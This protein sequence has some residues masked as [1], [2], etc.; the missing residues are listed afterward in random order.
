MLEDID[1]TQIE[2]LATARQ[3]ITRVLNLLETAWQETTD[4]KTE[5][6][7]LRDEVRQLKGE[8][9]VPK[10]KPRSKTSR[11]YSSEKERHKKTPRKK[12]SK[13]ARLVISR[14]EVLRLE[15][16]RLPED[17]QK[18]GY[19]DTVIQELRLVVET[20]RYRREKYYSPSTNQTYTAP[21]PAGYTGQFGPRAKAWALTLYYGA[22]L[23]EP[24]LLEFLATVG[25]SV[26]AT[27]LSS[28]LIEEYQPLWA[29]E[30]GALLKAGLASTSFAHLDQTSTPLNGKN[31]VTNILCNPFY[32]AYVTTEQADRLSVLRAL[33][34]GQAPTFHKTSLAEQLLVS[35]GL[36]QKWRVKLAGLGAEEV[37]SEKQLDQWL[38]KNLPG[39]GKQSRKLIKDALAIGAYQAQTEWPIVSTLICDDAAQFKLITLQLA[40]CWVHHARHYKLLTPKVV[41]HQKLLQDFLQRF[42]KYY[43]KLLAYSKLRA[44]DIE[45]AG[46]LR[47]EF[48]QLFAATGEYSQ[49]DARKA[50]SREQQT[51]LLMVLSQPEL[52][53][54]NNPAELGARQRVRKRDVSLQAVSEQG[55]SAW[56]SLQ[57]L[58]ATTKKLGVN[59]YE[60]LLDRLSGS[61]QLPSLPSLILERAEQGYSYQPSPKAQAK[62]LLGR[63]AHRPTWKKSP[64][65][66]PTVA[67]QAPPLNG[68][69]TSPKLI[70]SPAF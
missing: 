6:V 54:H 45:L 59:F 11:N 29:A 36:G 14:T 9:P 53:L 40:L 2:D 56:D 38:D 69:V 44:P 57:S 39:L 28:W 4:L 58:A 12:G 35:L 22:G 43:D 17:A 32:T 41:Y 30:V 62:S 42:F 49:L 34:G 8:Q 5:V 27:E 24:K 33:L 64:V 67:A 55:L 20:T 10:F 26:S 70:T 13:L 3:V 65:A 66:E 25:L 37:L 48:E 46:S 50:K 18:K 15:R 51:E 31:Q 7:R 19:A 21:L 16:S 60:Y 47:A 1:P 61:N 52:P 68:P 63:A 23:S